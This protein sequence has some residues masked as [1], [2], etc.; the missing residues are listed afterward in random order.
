MTVW[1]QEE[2][3]EDHYEEEEDEGEE[4]DVDEGTLMNTYSMQQRV[5][6]AAACRR[7]PGDSRCSHKSIEGYL[8]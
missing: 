5:A 3:E 7:Q 8:G 2:K 4:S 6:W 1:V